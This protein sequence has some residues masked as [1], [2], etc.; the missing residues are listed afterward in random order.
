MFLVGGP[1]FSGT[2]LLAHLLNQGDLVCLD[3]PDF[4]DPAQS[5]RGIPLLRTLFPD[6]SFPDP[7]G[8]AA[9]S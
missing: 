3:E 7:P 6:R 4:H 9:R 2:T 8:E 5:H 1:A